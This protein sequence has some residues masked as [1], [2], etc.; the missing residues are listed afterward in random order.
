MGRCAAEGEG[1]VRSDAEGG[2]GVAHVEGEAEALV[3]KDDEDPFAA[4][5][6]GIAVGDEGG[7]GG[8]VGNADDDGVAVVE[9]EGLEVGQSGI[10]VDVAEVGI[11]AEDGGRGGSRR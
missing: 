3:G 6:G 9:A 10:E 4:W 1:A 8:A 11:K 2:G 5:D 7:D